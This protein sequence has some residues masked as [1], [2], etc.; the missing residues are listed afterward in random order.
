MEATGQLRVGLLGT[1]TAS[2]DG[3]PLDLGG[4]RQRAVLAILVL[5]RGEVVPGERLAESLW[6]ETPPA[7]TAGALQ[8]SVSPLRRGE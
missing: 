3:A 7:D 1:F 8:A 5:A 6:G 2:W 4:P